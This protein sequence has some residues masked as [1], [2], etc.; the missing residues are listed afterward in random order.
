VPAFATFTDR[1]DVY[2]DDLKLELH[3]VGTAHTTN[4]VVVWIPERRL[5]FTGDIAFN[6]ATP[7]IVQGSLAGH[8]AAGER[9]REFGAERIVPGHGPS[10]DPGRWTACSTTCGSSGTWPRT[11]TPPASRLIEAA[12]KTDLG[13][14][15]KLD[16]RERLVANLHRA[17]SELRGEPRAAPLPLGGISAEVIEFNSGPICC[18]A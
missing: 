7:F 18:F 1:L 13:E 10:A 17:Y 3:Y 9:V 8:T 16:E 5:M 4:D 2:V 12:R 15:A 11:A 6:S 14:F